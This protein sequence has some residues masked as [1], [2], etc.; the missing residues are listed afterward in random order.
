LSA[1]GID[2]KLMP[3]K[4]AM[5]CRL[6]GRAGREDIAPTEEAVRL[7]VGAGYRSLVVDLSDAEHVSS[8]GLGLMLYYKKIL[9]E[10][11]GSLSVV[12]PP[13]HVARML[14]LINLDKVLQICSTLD[15]ALA[16]VDAPRGEP[17]D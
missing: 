11:G 1:Y 9:R 5:V 14:A 12:R 13:D 4:R 7:L 16:G 2:L 3:S 10:R 15:E 6:V 8:T 17:E